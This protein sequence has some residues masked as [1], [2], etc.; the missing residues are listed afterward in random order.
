M[1]N[2]ANEARLRPTWL[3]DDPLYRPPSILFDNEVHASTAV[4]GAMLSS[5][6][7]VIPATRS[8]KLGR[9]LKK[10]ERFNV[11]FGKRHRVPTHSRW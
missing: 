8:V 1:E 2:R 7:P 5:L 4:P 3:H 11:P 9:S 6:V 10:R